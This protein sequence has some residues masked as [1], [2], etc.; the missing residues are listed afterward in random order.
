MNEML[1]NN[2]LIRHDDIYLAN[3]TKRLI[4]FAN[5]KIKFV[6]TSEVIMANLCTIDRKKKPND[7]VMHQNYLK[8]L[9]SLLTPH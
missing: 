7:I 8:N 5:I 4:H 3:V 1:S 9:F 2:R 6:C